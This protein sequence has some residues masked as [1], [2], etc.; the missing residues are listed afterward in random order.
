[1]D[2]DGPITGQDVER[3]I[4]AGAA[5]RS[6]SA[7][8]ADVAVD[9]AG[10]RLLLTLSSGAVLGI[11]LAAVDAF[12]GVPLADL[13]GLELGTGGMALYLDSRDIQLDVLALVRPFIPVP[14]A[15]AVTASRGGQ[16]TTAAKQQAARL[17]GAK[18]GRP[19]RKAATP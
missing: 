17:N 8:A 15:A 5:R 6:S 19:R 1:M 13:A 11:P 10:G 12:R 7:W 2:I 18:G 9:A 3:A 4:V 14:L 16:A